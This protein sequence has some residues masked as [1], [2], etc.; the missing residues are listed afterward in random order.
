[1]QGNIFLP[2]LCKNDYVSK[3]SYNEQSLWAKP[4]KERKCLRGSTGSNFEVSPFHR[5]NQ[6]PNLDKENVGKSA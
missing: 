1:L 4:E 5:G 3:F 6:N 2:G